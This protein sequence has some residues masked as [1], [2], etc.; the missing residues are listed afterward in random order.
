MAKCLVTGGAGFIGSNLA[1][2]LEKLG[3]DVTASDNF[4]SADKGNLKG[5]RG[6]LIEWDCAIKKLPEGKFDLIF[7]QAA[8]TDPRY[9]DDKETYVKNVS[10]FKNILA[11]QERTGA[12]IIY[13]STAGLYGNGPI[14]MKEDQP[15]DCI[16]VYGESKWRMDQLAEGYFSSIPIVGLRYFNV[17]GPRE[18]H[19]GRPASMVLHLYRQ[20]KEG[21]RPRLF[22]QGEH[23]RDFIYIKDVVAANLCALTAPSGVYNV[24]TGVGTTFNDLVATLNDVLGTKLEP[25]YFEMPFDSKTY[26]HH[27]IADVTK[28]KDLLKFTAR[29]SLK[30]AVTD[31]IN[32]LE[33]DTNGR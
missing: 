10:G 11:L 3:H 29:Y 26:Q 8:I 17:F 18:A 33:G 13:A 22:K 4:H 28:A 7:H 16:T 15:K 9:P 31:Y 23:R 30:E 2:E 21:K 32:W 20:M 27:T 12:R 14:P 5:F 6:E 19:K 1:L 25:E 24:G